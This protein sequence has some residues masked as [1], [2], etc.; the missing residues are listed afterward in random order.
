VTTRSRS[1]PQSR[2]CAVG[3]GSDSQPG[4]R[5][6]QILWAG[7]SAGRKALVA[8]ATLRPGAAAPFL[9]LRVRVEREGAGYSLAVTNTTQVAEIAYAGTVLPLEIA[10]FLDRT[11]RESLAGDRLSPAYAT[12]VGLVRARDRRVRI[13]APFR[14]DGAL[15]FPGRP[16]SARGGRISGT[17]VFFART[18]GDGEPLSFRVDVRGGGGPPQLRLV[19]RPAPVARLLRPPGAATWRVA[20]RRRRIPGRALLERL[21]DTRM[22]LVRADQYQ[23]F[24]SN[25]DPGGRNR[26]VYVYETKAAP[27]P[28]PAASAQPESGGNVLLVTLV[29]VGSIAAAGAAV[30]TWAHS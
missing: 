24:L 3:P 5:T 11:R 28:T 30:V 9:P 23:S 25:P 14:V 21:I 1:R 2:T 18:V 10:R 6:G 29:V 4:L 27:S 13:E 7:F 8:D 20:V 26:T 22:R 12:F 16:S 19:A 17:T 15:R